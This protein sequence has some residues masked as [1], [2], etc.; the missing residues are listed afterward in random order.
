MKLAKISCPYC[1]KVV[2]VGDIAGLLKCK[3]CGKVFE[4]KRISDWVKPA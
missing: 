3:H 4:V 1:G 2:C